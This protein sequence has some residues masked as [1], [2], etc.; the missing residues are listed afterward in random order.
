MQKL[1]PSSHGFSTLSQGSLPAAVLAQARQEAAA[2]PG[3][4]AP[5]A[6][7]RQPGQGNTL[8]P[9]AAAVNR[10][11][12]APM[13]RMMSAAE[14]SARRVS[15]SCRHHLRHWSTAICHLDTAAVCTQIMQG[16]CCSRV[17][18]VAHRPRVLL[19]T[20]TSSGC[21]V[22]TGIISASNS[23]GWRSCPSS[24]VRRA[25]WS[26][27]R[28]QRPCACA[29]HCSCSA[30]LARTEC[31]RASGAFALALCNRFVCTAAAA[32]G[33]RSGCQA[34]GGRDGQSLRHGARGGNRRGQRRAGRAGS[35]QT[36]LC[37]RR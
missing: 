33:C 9:R 27:Y 24:G 34:G 11:G 26:L 28:C 20:L 17:H 3:H 7:S 8:A 15:D 32:R 2:L 25:R 21:C 22:L 10:S 1:G 6:P 14:A 30:S 12:S 37:R 4:T 13:A 23:Q 35:G 36:R 18:Y 29:V 5:E 31:R 16:C 19:T